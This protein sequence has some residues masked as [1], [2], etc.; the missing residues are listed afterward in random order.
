MIKI[1]IIGLGN[2]AWNVHLPI[3]LSRNDVVVSWIC[4]LDLEKKNIIEKKKIKFFNKIDQIVEYG[5]IDIILITT[6]YSERIKIFDKIKNLCKAIFFEKPY[7]RNLK[8]HSY[9]SENFN[10]RFMTVGYTRRKMG[11]VQTVKKIIK[12]KI[13]GDLESVKIF[14]G[15]IHY[16]FDGFR[17]NVKESGGGIFLEAGTHWID[18]VLF[19]TNAKKILNLSLNKKEKSSL[20]IE[21]SGMFEFI[22]DEEKRFECEFLISILQNTSNKIEYNFK[23]CSV[24]LFLFEDESNLKIKN[25]TN[26]DLLIKDNEFLNFPSNSFD[27]TNSFWEDFIKSI[28][29]KEKSEISLDTFFLTTKIVEMFYED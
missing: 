14:F 6:P 18:C 26:T 25:K 2:V 13:F 5:K 7:A 29:N 16:K 27:V 1:G 28:K 19:T 20:D 22:N 11:I 23:N 12:Q 15:D 17:S 3:L 10:S 8:E 4:D 9:F 24:E 21:S